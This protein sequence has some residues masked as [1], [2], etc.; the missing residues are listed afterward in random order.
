MKRGKTER[1]SNSGDEGDGDKSEASVGPTKDQT[2]KGS[3]SKSEMEQTERKN[4]VKSNTNGNKDQT[5][6]IKATD[7]TKESTNEEED[8]EME[9]G[10]KE[11]KRKQNKSDKRGGNKSDKDKKLKSSKHDK[12]KEQ[13][14]SASEKSEEEDSKVE[15]EKDEKK[16]LTNTQDTKSEKKSKGGFIDFFCEYSSL[17]T[18]IL[19]YSC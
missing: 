13:C 5:E 16:D 3:E 9:E 15:K 7:H 6:E 4:I 1:V 10:K 17:H 18:D 2:R 8:T 11:N 14:I 12:T 19:Y